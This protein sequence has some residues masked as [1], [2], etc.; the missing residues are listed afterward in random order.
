MV[1][2]ALPSSSAGAE[3]QDIF[4]AHI[5]QKMGLISQTM[6]E[7]QDLINQYLQTKNKPDQ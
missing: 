5:V 7:V 2:V 4:L 3:D 1:E 6:A